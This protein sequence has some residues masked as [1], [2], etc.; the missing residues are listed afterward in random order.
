[1]AGYIGKVQPEDLPESTHIVT[2]AMAAELA[3]HTAQI[4]VMALM[5][6]GFH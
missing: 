3:H 6:F 5:T 1:M 4:L 2:V